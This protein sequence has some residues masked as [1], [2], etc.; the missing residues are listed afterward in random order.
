MYPIAYIKLYLQFFVIGIVIPVL[1]LNK[2]NLR[3]CK[4]L[5]YFQKAIK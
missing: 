2:L 3:K 1:Y 4:W 5:S